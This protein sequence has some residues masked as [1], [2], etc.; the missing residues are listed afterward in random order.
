VRQVVHHL[1]DSHCNSFI[2]FKLALTEDK[3]TI[4][5]YQEQLWA[6]LADSKNAS[7]TPSLYLLENLHKKWV[8]VLQNIQANEWQ[9]KGFIHP[10]KQRLVTLAEAVALYAWHGEHHLAHIH[11]LQERMLWKK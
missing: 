3:P 9:T 7:I 5:P 1:A 2:R 8:L 11:K 4:K 6:E 10:E